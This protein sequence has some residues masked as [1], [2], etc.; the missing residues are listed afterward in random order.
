MFIFHL[1]IYESSDN[2]YTYITNFSILI[3]YNMVPVP[4]HVYNDI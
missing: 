3:N 1:V 4:Y 2:P